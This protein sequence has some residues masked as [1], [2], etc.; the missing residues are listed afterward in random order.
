MYSTTG[1]DGRYR[2]RLTRMMPASSDSASVFIRAVVIPTLP[3]LV[4]TIKDSVLTRVMVTPIGR[5]PDTI[6]V[7][8]VLP[9]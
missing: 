6:F 5:V 7:N 3:Q 2:F 1:L 8:F 4:A 9:R